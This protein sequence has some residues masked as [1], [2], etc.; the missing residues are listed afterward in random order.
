MSRLPAIKAA[1]LG[2]GNIGVDLGIKLSKDPRFQ[3]VGVAGRRKD[4][5]GYRRLDPLSSFATP[6]GLEGLLGI[7]DA[8]DIIFDATNAEAHRRHWEVLQHLS[9][10]VIDLTPSRIGAPT[11]PGVLSPESQNYSMIT[12]GG[13]SA[14]PLIN[15]ITRHC[16]SVSYVEVSS[17]IASRSAGPA[18]R[19]NLDDYILATQ[20][21]ARAVSRAADAKAILILNPVEPPTLMRTTVQMNVQDPSMQSISHAVTNAVE[22]VHTYVPGYELAVPPHLD[23]GLLTLTVKVTGAGDYLPPWAGNLDIITAAAV[24]TAAESSPDPRI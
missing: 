9:P 22:S 3:L 11:V 18:T 13:Q 16:A 8:T 10:K 21:A 12:C 1:I 2:T 20:N 23:D 17:S 14:L 7:L 4:S 15:A 5:A 6:N 19:I 24:A